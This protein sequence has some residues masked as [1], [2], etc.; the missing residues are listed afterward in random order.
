V[1]IICAGALER[2][3]DVAPRACDNDSLAVDAAPVERTVELA[4]RDVES[5]VRDGE[6]VVRD[7]APESAMRVEAGPRDAS[8]HGE[9]A[10]VERVASWF[11]LSE[12]SPRCVRSAWVRTDAG[13][14]TPVLA[15]EY[16]REPAPP[17]PNGSRAPADVDDTRPSE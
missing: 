4:V 17:A 9:P 16:V 7:V 14:A 12:P 8:P 2:E 15:T 13:P 3:Y 6:P 10:T 11:A 1:G 5:A